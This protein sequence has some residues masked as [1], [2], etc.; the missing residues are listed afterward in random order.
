MTARRITWGRGL[1]GVFL[2]GAAILLI[3]GPAQAVEIINGSSIPAG[4]VINDH[5]LIFN[6]TV[7]VDGTVNGDL[8]AFGSN[9]TINGTVNG[10]LFTGG[11]KLVINGKVQTTAYSAGQSMTIGEQASIGQD[12]LYGGLTYE[13]KPGSTI[14]R[15]LMVASYQANVGGNIGR[16]LQTAVLLLRISG[17][18]GCDVPAAA[19]STPST[20]GLAPFG[21]T[22]LVQEVGRRLGPAGLARAAGVL[23]YAGI[24]NQMS[25]FD[26]PWTGSLAFRPAS[27]GTPG[28][29]VVNWQQI[30]MWALER[31]KE[32]VTLLVVG[33][34]VLV[35]LPGVMVRWGERIRKSPFRA[36]GTGLVAAIL[37][38]SGALVFTL[39][40]VAVFFFLIFVK[41]GA[42][43]WSVL[44]LG[45]SGTWLAYA[46]FA[47]AVSYLSKLAVGY[48]AGRWILERVSARLAAR[49]FWPMLLGTIL[50]VL[51]RSIPWLGWAIAVAVTLAGL[52]AVWLV[53]R[54]ERRPYLSLLS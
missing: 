34:I 43:G 32:L 54:E 12:F 53:L 42:L 45:L 27:N 23:T 11:Q 15:D 30:G 5:V 4:R 51:L 3:V 20:G 16:D 19:P 8:F 7:V 14:G 39:V 38:Y 33:V 13:T 24:V 18:L 40:I 44:G 49:A 46:L 10:N 2:A 41:L 36:A 47:L 22:T 35:A 6:P 52:G 17:K 31:V 9:V 21:P 29:L 28:G 37:G 1:I 48:L 26:S 50:Y 25:P